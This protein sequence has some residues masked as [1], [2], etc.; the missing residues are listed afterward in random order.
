MKYLD[1][2]FNFTEIKQD[3][4]KSCNNCKWGGCLMLCHLTE[5]KSRKYCILWEG[6]KKK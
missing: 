5:A 3:F 4:Q 1:L 2:D 6:A